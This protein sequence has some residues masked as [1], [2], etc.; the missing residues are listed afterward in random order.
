MNQSLFDEYKFDE[1]ILLGS[2]LNDSYQI[3]KEILSKLVPG[4]IK[5]IDLIV[6]KL[7]EVFKRYQIN[8]PLR[9]AHFLA[10]VITESGGFKSRVENLNYSSQRLLT[11]FPKYF[12][13]E[14]SKSYANNPQRIAN[15]VYANRGGNGSEL[16][17][18]GW[19]YRGRGFI[20]LTFKNN[21]EKIGKF[22]DY[23]FVK[24]PE[25][26]EK[27]SAAIY[28][29]AAYWTMCNINRWADKDSLMDVTK[30][31][32]GGYNGL[33][34]RTKNLSICKKYILNE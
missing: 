15:R 19:R 6:V 1:G 17:G 30:A 22:L 21:Y 8:T 14:T 33:P 32:N 28:S 27:T 10:Q 2:S 23:D 16:S 20:Q 18:D 31:V 7:N 3:T 34:D 5:D 4:T 25:S 24:D 13:L 12:N 29:A 11:V 9:V 26:L